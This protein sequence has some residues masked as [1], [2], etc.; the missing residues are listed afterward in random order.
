[1]V[2]N[3]QIKYLVETALLGHGL[4]SIKNTNILSIWPKDAMLAWVE[5]G[6][7]RVGTIEEFLPTRMKSDHWKRF[8]GLKIRKSLSKD[9]NGYLTASGTMIVAKKLRCPVV[10][11]AGI[12]GIGD[13][14][15][16]NL[17]YD[18]PALAELGITLVATSPKDMLDI[19]ATINWLKNHGVKVLGIDTEYCNGYILALQNHKLSGRV[20]V[21]DVNKLKYGCNLILNPIPKEERLKDSLLL[22]EAIK[23]GKQAEK[24]GKA[25]H[26]AVNACFDRLSLGMSSKIQLES[27]V[28]NIKLA[29]LIT[30]N[31]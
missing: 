11:T 12:G 28:S 31:R 23:S 30:N 24:E 27:L 14:Y 21:Q 1:M 6:E 9:V 20:S 5:K 15:R 17:C 18:L 10:V 8:N 26:P 4:P 25:Y 29:E 2:G 3:R 13:I 16:E 19:P 22:Q 7:I